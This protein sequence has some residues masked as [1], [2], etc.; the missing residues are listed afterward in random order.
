MHRVPE[1]AFDLS[2]SEPLT[3]VPDDS[4]ALARHP[5]LKDFRSRLGA[6]PLVEV[7]SP[8]GGA[9]ILAKLEFANPFGSVKDRAAYALFCG[10]ITDHGDRPEQLRLVD[11]SGGNM[12][13]ALGG[14]GA[15]TGI[16]VRLAVPDSTPPSLLGQ[17]RADHV[18]L[19]FVAAE[20]FLYGI[21]RRA[22]EIAAVDP[23]LRILHQHRNPL[24]LAVHE[25]MTGAEIVGQ[26]DGRTPGHWVAAIGTGGTIAGITRALRR[27]GGSPSVVGVTPAEMPYGT[28]Q[29][30]NGQRKF[31]GAGGFGYGMRQPFVDGFVPDASQRTVPY[32]EALSAMIRFRELTGMAIGASAAANWSVCYS[33]AETLGDDQVVLTLFADAG[34]PEDWQR[35]EVLAG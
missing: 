24:N 1:R 31:A 23:G 11:F 20:Q 4:D 2:I 14:L 33:L 13:R 32:H 19:D 18:H 17:L 16:P 9:T 5:A 8:P 25:F 29:P 12:A 15:L 21:I 27:S 35:A 6:T 22:G 10:A 30:P 28:A 26:L 7:S 3:A 34:T